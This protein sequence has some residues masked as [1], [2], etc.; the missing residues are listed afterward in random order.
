M[1]RQAVKRSD[2]IMTISHFSHSEI[3]KYTGIDETKVTPIHLGVDQSHF[4]QRKN[5][6]LLS[7]VRTKYGLP[8][9]FIVFVSNLAVHKNLNGL[10]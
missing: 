9:K 4:F 7:A 5:L 2:H 10:S 6:N 3:V 8:E 1:I